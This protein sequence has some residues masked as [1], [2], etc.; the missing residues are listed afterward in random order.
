MDA[1]PLFIRSFRRFGLF[2][3]VALGALASVALAPAGDPHG[4]PTKPEKPAAAPTGDSAGHPEGS[5]APVAGKTPADH[6]SSPPSEPAASEKPNAPAVQAAHGHEEVESVPADIALRRLIEGNARF[7][8]DLDNTT[9][10]DTARRPQLAAG[11]RPF[12]IILSCADSRVPPELVFDQELGDL[13]VVRVAGNIADDACLGSIEYA[14][15]HLG[16]KLIVVLGHTK[17]GAVKAAVDTAGAGKQAD[18]L[19]G[20]LPAV[21][22]PI[23][24]AVAETS[25]MRGDSVKLA[26]IR[27][28]QRT[29]RAL[30]QCGPVIAGAVS[31][32]GVRVMGAVY[33][34]ES[35]DVDLVPEL[36]SEAT[37]T[38]QTVGATQSHEAPEH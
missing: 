7:S 6:G 12:A 23:M 28:V 35:G 19:P 25:S 16:A 14:V 37:P 34:L 30:Q 3:I 27:N 29:V 17:C 10:R 18:T 32:K 8:H 26:V 36:S 31:E 22:T 21:V 20:H 5:T 1:C 24:P 4:P 38:T 33:D 15:D 11:Q 13:F 2:S 9:P